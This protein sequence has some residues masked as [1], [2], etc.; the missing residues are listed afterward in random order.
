MYEFSSKL[1]RSQR[2]VVLTSRSFY[3]H[4]SR[5]K[6]K[7]RQRCTPWYKMFN[8]HGNQFSVLFKIHGHDVFRSNH[9][10]LFLSPEVTWP[11]C[12][13]LGRL[14]TTTLHSCMERLVKSNIVRLTMA[15]MAIHEAKKVLRREIKKR[16][17]AMTNEAKLKESTSIVSKVSLESSIFRTFR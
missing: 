2:F 5:K 6:P 10:F 9:V 1:K 3:L 15:Q 16:V 7:L 14:G 11:N 4:S 13:F 12:S 8:I 17:A